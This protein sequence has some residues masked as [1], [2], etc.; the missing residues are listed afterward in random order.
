MTITSTAETKQGWDQVVL[1]C[2]IEEQ[3]DQREL[4][5]D[6]KWTTE[7]NEEIKSEQIQEDQMPAK[8]YEVDWAG[9]YNLMGENVRCF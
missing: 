8:L 9:K 5:Y 2:D 6:V 4:F 1:Y 7:N 3:L